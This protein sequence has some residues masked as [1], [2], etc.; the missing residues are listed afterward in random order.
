M[1]FNLK[2]FV[3]NH[4]LPG[5]NAML[6][7]LSLKLVTRRTPNRNF[8]EFFE[9][10]AGLGVRM[11]TVID[12]GVGNGTETLYAANPGARFV[13]VEPVPDTR[14]TV[15]AI[16]RRLDAKFFN[17]A[18]GA[19]DGE[20]DFHLHDD[21]TGSSMYRQLEGGALDGTLVKVPVRRLDDII[22]HEVT[23]PC[24]LKIDTQGAEVDVID[25]AR[26]LLRSVDIAIIEVS[27]HQFREGAVEMHEVVQA[28]VAAGFRCYEVLEGHYRSVDNA[29]AQVDLVFVPE[30][31]ALRSVKTFFSQQQVDA[32]LK[33]GTL[34]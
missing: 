21:I 24:L 32:Y 9:H 2:Q 23:R 16:A 26:Q 22:G 25:G 3:Y 34:R 33:S 8:K 29:L 10:L 17:V 14:G 27:F 15:A 31:S 6:R 13:L 19:R 1:A 11:K 5:I 30:Q 4:V 20:I 28:M 12:V 18:A 7:P